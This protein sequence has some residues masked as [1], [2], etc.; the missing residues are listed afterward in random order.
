M[1]CDMAVER[2]LG[3]DVGNKRIGVAVSDGLGITVQPVMTLERRRSRREDLRSL[4]RLAR[5]YGVAGIVLGNPLHASGEVSPQAVKTQAFAAELGEL[6]GLPIHM[7]DE[8]LTSHEAHQML[9]E[10]GHKRQEHRALVDQVAAVLILESFM[11]SR[12]RGVGIRDQE[13]EN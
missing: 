10:A 5:R 4:G 13:E 7:W 9:Y 11:E 3:L 2:F 8:R 12:G 1:G 6:T